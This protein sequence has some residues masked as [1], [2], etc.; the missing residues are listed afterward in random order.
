MDGRI[1]GN[2]GTPA[3]LTRIRAAHDGGAYARN[4]PRAFDLFA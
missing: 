1:S 4:H 2:D 3:V